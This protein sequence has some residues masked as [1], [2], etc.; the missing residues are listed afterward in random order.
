MNAEATIRRNREA[1][2]TLIQAA[3]RAWIGLSIDGDKIVAV[4]QTS[5]GLEIHAGRF[6]YFAS[7]IPASKIR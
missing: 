6:C 3:R 7:S 5:N 1:G 4:Q 2:E